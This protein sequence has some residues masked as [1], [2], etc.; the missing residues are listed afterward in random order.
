VD[1]NV[2]D[3]YGSIFIRL[4]PKSAKLL[5]IPRKFELVA[6]QG[7]PKLSISLSIES[8]C[9]IFISH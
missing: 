1:Y 4:P 6:V 9:A 8:A 3:K 2:A 5:E 7:H